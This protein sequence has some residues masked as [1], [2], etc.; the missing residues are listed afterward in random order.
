M[1]GLCTILVVVGLNLL[2][3][4]AHMFAIFGLAFNDSG[5]VF[6]SVLHLF[7]NMVV[8]IAPL[9]VGSV[10][11]IR[12]FAKK[13]DFFKPVA[14]VVQGLLVLF[15]SIAYIHSYVPTSMIR[16]V[17][18]SI[19]ESRAEKK[20]K[21]RDEAARKYL[22]DKTVGVYDDIENGEERIT[23]YICYDSEKVVF[24]YIDESE[25]KSCYCV[26]DANYI[27]G[28]EPGCIV[29]YKKLDTGNSVIRG[30]NGLIYLE[31]EK[32]RYLCLEEWGL[33][34]YCEEHKN[35]GCLYFELLNRDV[36]ENNYRYL[37]NDVIALEIRKSGMSCFITEES[38]RDLP[39]LVEGDRFAY[40][41]TILRNGQEVL[42]RAIPVG[43]YSLNLEEL[44]EKYW[45][46]EGRYEIYL[47]TYFNSNTYGA[48]YRGYIKASN[49]VFW[50][51]AK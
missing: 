5:C 12:L 23:I 25:G 13:L 26:A 49:S 14:Y 47:N 19:E 16:T 43:E 32:N 9:A 30:T 3:F 17:A 38:I 7:P 10:I 37:P 40:G 21:E 39:V 35:V 20:Q 42:S 28:T 50:D 2:L 1:K 33:N 4:F 18:D 51:G 24:Q 44:P 15:Y 46:Q 11:F 6:P 41:W 22:S 45:N 27:E 36:I 48:E 8:C 29:K 34:V 31:V